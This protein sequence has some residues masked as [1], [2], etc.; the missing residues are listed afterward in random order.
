MPRRKFRFGGARYDFFELVH[1]RE[2]LKV[3]I[4]KVRH[5]W[6]IEP[7]HLPEEDNERSNAIEKFFEDNKYAEEVF[8]IIRKLGLPIKFHEELMQ[9]IVDDG[10]NNTEHFSSQSVHLQTMG[11]DWFQ[12][13]IG[14]DATFTDLTKIWQTILDFR[15]HPLRKERSRDNV[16]RDMFI[17]RWHKEGK[18]AKEI[19]GL[20]KSEEEHAEIATIYKVISEK[21]KKFKLR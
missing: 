10:N 8:Q 20:L 14:P 13:T 7:Q 11:N 4:D 12:I 18:S 17:F 6:N 9:Y 1:Y 2:D 21:K 3:E 16:R 19:Y 15:D 5:K